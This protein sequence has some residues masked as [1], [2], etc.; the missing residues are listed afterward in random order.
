[1]IKVEID[2]GVSEFSAEGTGVELVANCLAL[3]SV[4][5]KHLAS[6]SQHMSDLY[7]YMV[8]KAIKEGTMFD[9]GKGKSV[10]GEIFSGTIEEFL[11][12]AEGDLPFC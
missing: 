8:A 5:S 12:G 3:V 9:T 7:E 2:K 6:Q 11:K 10:R 1:M 4:L